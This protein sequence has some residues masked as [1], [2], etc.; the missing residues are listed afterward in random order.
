MKV[1]EQHIDVATIIMD[2]FSMTGVTL[3]QSLMEKLKYTN[4]WFNN[5]NSSS[6]QLPYSGRNM[7]F[8]GDPY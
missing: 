1:L 2:E 7:I 3:W 4:S 8:I 6:S 5:L